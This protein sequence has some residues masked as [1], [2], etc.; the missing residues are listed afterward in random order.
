MKTNSLA[1][2]PE[3]QTVHPRSLTLTILLAALLTFCVQLASA[4][5]VMDEIEVARGALKADRKIV[6]AEGMQLTEKES[7]AF[8]PIYREYRAAMDT[9]ADGRVELVLEYG[10]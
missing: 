6:I 10:E 3:P 9:V 1:P 5:N 8:W 7:S 4:Q 2:K